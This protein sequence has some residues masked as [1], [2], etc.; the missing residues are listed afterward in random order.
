MMGADFAPALTNHIVSQTHDD[1]KQH[2]AIFLKVAVAIL[3][4]C[5]SSAHKL[6]APDR[7]SAQKARPTLKFTG[8]PC[9]QARPQLHETGD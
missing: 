4:S 7:V 9:G 1:I 8:A 5:R 2:A 6:E 3:S